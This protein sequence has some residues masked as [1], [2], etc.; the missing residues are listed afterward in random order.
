M[1]RSIVYQGARSENILRIRRQ[2]ADLPPKRDVCIEFS[3][4]SLGQKFGDHHQA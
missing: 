2:C 1:G 4:T 3:S